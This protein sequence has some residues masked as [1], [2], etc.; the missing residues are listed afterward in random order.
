VG[1][2]YSCSAIGTRQQLQRWRL[3]VPQRNQQE[4]LRQQAQPLAAAAAATAVAHVQLLLLL[5]RK[6][7][8]W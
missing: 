2:S 1:F 5:L 4:Q 6:V 3:D 7:Y 8:L